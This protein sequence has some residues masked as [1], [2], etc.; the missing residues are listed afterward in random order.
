MRDES[1]GALLKRF[2]LGEA[3]A[4]ERLVERHGSSVYA[5][6]RRFLGADPVVEDAYQEV[7]L[8][9]IRYANQFEGRSRFTTW[10]FQ[11]TRNVCMDHRRSTMRKK[12]GISLERD[13]AGASDGND[14]V[15]LR[16]QIADRGASTEERVATDEERAHIER[17]IAQ[18]P[19]EQREVLLL[20]EKTEL[21][22]E[23]IAEI[24]GLSPNT[25]KSRMR[26][27]LQ[28]LRKALKGVAHGL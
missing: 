12:G 4:M 3:D 23:E 28:N 17:A 16:D 26:Y 25:V 7:W 9:V 22:F 6:V 1:E 10:L 19:D 27:A 8:K 11:I 18:L 15:P 14:G 20:R 21:T 24:A 2:A 13:G 5:F